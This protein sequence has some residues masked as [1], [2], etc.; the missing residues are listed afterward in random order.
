MDNT[1][2]QQKALDDALVALENRLM[3]RKC[4]QRLSSTLK[5]IEPTIQVALDALKLTPFYNA[6]KVSADVPEIYMQEFWATVTKHHYSLRFKL[7]G[8][9]HTVNVDNFRDMLKICPKL[10]GQKF[11]EP[12]FEEEIISLIRDLGYTCDIKVLSD[13]NINHMHQPW[14]S[15]AVIIN[16]CLSGKTTGL[17][18]LHLSR[19]QLLW[20]MYYNKHID[21]VYLLWEDLM[22]Q[23]ENKDS[24]K[25]NDMFYPCFTKVIVD[26]FM[27]NDPSISRRNKMFWHNARDDSMFTTI[28]HAYATGEK[29]PKPK[30]KKD[31]FESSP[32]EK[33]AQASKGKRLKTPS[34]VAQSTKKKQP[35]TKSKAKG[36]I[37]LSKVALTEAEQ[38][39]LATKRSLIQTHSSHA[40][41]SGDGVDTL[42]KVPDEQLQKKSE[43]DEGDE[44][45]AHDDSD[46]NESDDEGDDFVHPNL[47]TYTADDQDKE[48]N[49]EEEKVEDD[50][51]LSDQRVEKG[52]EE[53]EDEEMIYG[54]LNLNRESNDADMSE[55]QAT[56]NTEDAHVTLTAVTPVV[57]QQSS[58]VSDLV[59]KF[60]NPST[61][62]AVSFI[63]SIIDNYLASKMKEAVDVAVQLKSNKLREE[64]QAEN[65]DFINSL[66]SNM[67]KIIKE[68]TSYAVASSLSELELKKIL[69][70]KMEENKSI[71]RSEVQK[72][73]YNAL[74]EAYNTDKDIISTYGD[75]VTISRG[76][77]DEDKDEEPSA[78][79]NRGTK[80]RRSGKETE[81]TNEPTHKESRITSSSR[82]ASRSQPT[83][84]DDSTHQEFNTGDEDV[85]P[86][87][88]A[89]D[90]PAGSQSSFDE[91]MA[92]PI[93]FSAFMMNWLKID[94][95][96]QELLTG[97]T[98][99]L[100]KGSCKSVAELEYHLE[101]V[102]KATND[103]LDWNNSKGTPYPH[104]LNKPLPLIPNARG[105][106]V[107]PFNHFIKNNLEYIKGGSLSHKYTTSITKTKAADCGQIKWI[108]DKIPR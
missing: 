14:R 9:S 44:S 53:H 37:V 76:H 91:L 72:N 68:Q 101:E 20:G 106:L 26:Y 35:A 96:T 98:Y 43:T 107:I 57:Q 28:R 99:D 59:L 10:L 81:L 63:P 31:D 89:Q 4:N 64:A 52:E 105:H 41:G 8:K 83:N 55:A 85:T 104:D 102:F 39:K 18:R 49:Q 70:D 6:F 27:A 34:K 45:D 38:M 36:L 69:M 74:V 87:R 100:M 29:T 50:E 75:V 58:S 12:P 56:K 108:K 13:V 17:E 3:I 5:S 90:E 7:N 77:G 46:E 92:T 25:N 61:D 51:D 40:S 54:D 80:R 16:K 21:Y 73:L 84:F 78:G 30:K 19:A 11:E 103:Q 82:G 24:K 65:Q 93:D 32:N 62:E 2:A 94:Y 67:N 66:D 22:F 47:S 23:V 42:S 97:P 88:E 60:I 33:P 95:L 15:L 71:D 48:E 79:S 86:T 1:K